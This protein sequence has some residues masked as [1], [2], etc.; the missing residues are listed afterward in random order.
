MWQL[1]SKNLEIVTVSR[2]RGWEQNG[3]GTEGAGREGREGRGI[4]GKKSKG[5]R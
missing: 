4:E 2:V 5:D 3:L 1:S